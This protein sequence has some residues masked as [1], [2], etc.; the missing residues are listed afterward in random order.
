MWN[1]T[2]RRLELK[3]CP[4][5]LPGP[6]NLAHSLARWLSL[7]IRRSLLLFTSEIKEHVAVTCTGVWPPLCRTMA[8]GGA[9]GAAGGS[10]ATQF[11]ADTISGIINHC[12]ASART[13]TLVMG[14]RGE[15]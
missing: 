15:V 6:V 13:P 1:V 3:C 8:R 10:S 2:E 11:L 5:H 12:E 14:S 9:D 7:P 4:G